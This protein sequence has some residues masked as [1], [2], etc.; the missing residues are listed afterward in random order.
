M[1]VIRRLLAL[2]VAIALAGV[3]GLVITEAIGI[4]LDATGVLVPVD[5]WERRLTS[6]DW[7]SWSNHA[8]TVA[9]GGALAL[10][11]TLIVLQ[12]IPHRTPTVDRRREGHERQ[13]RFGRGGLG[14]RLREVVVDQDGVIGGR[15]AVRRRKIAVEAQVTKG[16][17]RRATEQAVGAAV[18]EE[19]DRLRLAR[20]PRVRVDAVHTKDRVR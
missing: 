14:H 18:R 11:L 16:G 9:S 15:A 4:R 3:A 1:T 20:T 10:G 7:S 19:L 13:V 2:L 5:E 17:D 8:W 12:L 6:G